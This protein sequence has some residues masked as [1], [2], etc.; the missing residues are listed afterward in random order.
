MEVAVK[1]KR[2]RKVLELVKTRKRKK[3]DTDLEMLPTTVARVRSHSSGVLVAPTSLEL[4]TSQGNTIASCKLGVNSNFA[5][6]ESNDEDDSVEITTSNSMLRESDAI[7]S[8]D[9]KFELH[10][11]EL[12][13]KPQLAK[14]RCRRSNAEA[15]MPSEVELDE[16]F[17]VAEKD[18]HK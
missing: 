1:M 8:N 13:P 6:N 5:D 9:F 4:F 17:V 10:K 16:F 15:K 14:C 11:L 18:L 7:L 12:T 3:S 2:E